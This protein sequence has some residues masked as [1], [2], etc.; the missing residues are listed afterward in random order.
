M[1]SIWRSQIYYLFGFLFAVVL[2]QIIISSQIAIIIT[3]IQ[4]C[5]KNYRW[6]WKC[7]IVSGSSAIWVFLYSIYYYLDVLRVKV[8]SGTILYFGYM[9]ILSFSLF[10]V[11]GSVGVISTF[12]F[13]KKIYSMT[14][15]N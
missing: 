14:K 5:R 13:L 10:V 12:F 4:L 15:I 8:L 2:L 9:I 3:Y 6:W 7:F 1:K 11:C